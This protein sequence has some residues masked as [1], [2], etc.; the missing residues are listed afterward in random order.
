MI[1]E[2]FS[3]KECPRGNLSNEETEEARAERT[4]STGGLECAKV[5]G[6]RRLQKCQ[7]EKQGQSAGGK[8]KRGAPAVV[9]K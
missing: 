8:G 5:T 4:A 9:E 7:V 2:D 6:Q 1:T 3:A